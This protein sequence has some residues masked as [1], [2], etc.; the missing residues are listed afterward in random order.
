MQKMRLFLHSVHASKICDSGTN[1]LQ[2]LASPQSIILFVADKRCMI[3]FLGFS[4]VYSE[5]KSASSNTELILKER[6][7][8]SWTI[9]RKKPNS[10]VVATRLIKAKYVDEILDALAQSDFPWTLDIAGAGVEEHNLK[11]YSKKLHLENSVNFCG[12]LTRDSVLELMANRQFYI[13]A[14]AT[15]GMP[16]AVLEAIGAGCIPIL[17]D[18]DP[19]LEFVEEG[20]FAIIFRRRDQQ[21]F[22]DALATASML[23][24]IRIEEIVSANFENLRSKFS[25][26]V[27]MK[28][29]E[30]LVEGKQLDLKETVPV[31]E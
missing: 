5:K 3:L 23:D 10:L 20:F 15:D 7:V 27:M 12:S 16:I 29:Y 14:S 31:N 13:S 4:K 8:F 1:F 17:V 9:H 28:E 21:S 2:L 6:P 19:H 11:Q 18:S 26:E 25:C 24:S 30:S 22:K